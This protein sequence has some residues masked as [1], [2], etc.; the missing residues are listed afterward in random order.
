M[1]REKRSRE[2]KYF[3]KENHL[4]N[5]GKEGICSIGEKEIKCDMRQEENVKIE[6]ALRVFIFIL[7]KKIGN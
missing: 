6:V 7:R 4:Q 5:C 1:L 3:T 2:R